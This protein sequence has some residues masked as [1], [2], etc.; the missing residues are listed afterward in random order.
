M[1]G[2]ACFD[3]LIE[4]SVISNNEVFTD[5]AHGITLACAQKCE[6][7]NN[8]VISTDPTKVISHIAI[9]T[10]KEAIPYESANNLV[11]NNTCSKYNLTG[12]TKNLGN[13][14]VLEQDVVALLESELP[15]AA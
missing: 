13:L 4:N 15:L 10:N 14:E 6:I 9:A 2:I 7:G 8:I 1:Q 12:V 11:T 5:H 3:G